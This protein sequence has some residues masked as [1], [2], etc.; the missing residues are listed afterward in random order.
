[1]RTLREGRRQFLWRK[2]IPLICLVSSK[3][4][5]STFMNA[6]HLQILPQPHM[7]AQG[8]LKNPSMVFYELSLLS[9]EHAKTVKKYIDTHISQTLP[10]KWLLQ[11]CKIT[12]L[13]RFFRRFVKADQNY[14][15]LG[16]SNLQNW[17]LHRFRLSR[18]LEE[19]THL[20]MWWRKC[21]FMVH[22]RLLIFFLLDFENR[23]LGLWEQLV[24]P[25]ASFPVA[26][27]VEE[28]A[29]EME[30]SSKPKL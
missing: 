15:S 21:Y 22:K 6:Y 29:I 9:G 3:S 24:N 1:M 8:F 10:K 27:S 28:K 13:W 12:P 26:Q 23:G 18:D 14:G 7:L 2:T 5:K 4:R 16:T 19:Q 25:L 17:R 11:S 30:H 20:C